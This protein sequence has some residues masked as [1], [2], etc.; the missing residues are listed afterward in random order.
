[1]N[2]LLEW[3]GAQTCISQGYTLKTSSS[4]LLFQYIIFLNIRQGY[5]VQRQIWGLD[6]NTNNLNDL[7]ILNI[8]FND[9]MGHAY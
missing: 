9:K 3:K 8:G 4:H 7:I 1:M 5:I 2:Y 6:F